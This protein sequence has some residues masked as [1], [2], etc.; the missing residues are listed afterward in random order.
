MNGTCSLEA[1]Q[2]FWRPF[3]KSRPQIFF[4]R[5]ALPAS[6]RKDVF[7]LSLL[8][9]FPDG[10]ACFQLRLHRDMHV[11]LTSQVIGTCLTQPDRLELWL[12]LPHGKFDRA[13]RRR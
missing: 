11:R 3:L 7:S 2:K 5:L 1:A 8:G 13:G 4:D 12:L 10:V 6:G 9:L